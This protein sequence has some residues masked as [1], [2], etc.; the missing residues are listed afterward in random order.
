MSYFIQ[1]KDHFHVCFV[2]NHFHKAV[3][4]ELAADDRFEKSVAK[5]C[6]FIGKKGGQ[7]SEYVEEAKHLGALI[8]AHWLEGDCGGDCKNLADSK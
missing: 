7:R 8:T 6:H 5:L 2:D 4:F 1:N 3:A